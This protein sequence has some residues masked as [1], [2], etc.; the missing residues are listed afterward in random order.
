VRDKQGDNAKA[1]AQWGG[2]VIYCGF[3][4]TV[5]TPMPTKDHLICAK[6]AMRHFSKASVYDPGNRQQ[7]LRARARYMRALDGKAENTTLKVYMGGRQVRI[8]CPSTS[9]DWET[10][11]Y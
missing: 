7:L 3:S 1:R 10:L 9:R 2:Q 4:C 8:D 5:M 11:Y 6:T